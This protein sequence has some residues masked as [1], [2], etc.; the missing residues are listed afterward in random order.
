MS[1]RA[2]RFFLRKADFAGGKMVLDRA[3]KKKLT[4]VLRLGAGDTV[5]ILAP[6]KK[7]ECTISSVLKDGVE[8]E[9]VRELAASPAP[10]CEL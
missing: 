2:P 9:M 10:R 5:E 8:V 7:W 4:R 1:E 3:A 6:G